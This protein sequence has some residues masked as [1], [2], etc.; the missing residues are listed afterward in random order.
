[1]VTKGETWV[2]GK[3]AA[4]DEYT[5]ITIC[6]IDNN[7]DLLYSTENSPQYSVITYHGK[8]S[9]KVCTDTH[10]HTHIH[11]AELAVHWKPTQ[12][13]KSDQTLTILE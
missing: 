1:L 10:T 6:K 12:N 3:S 5:H 2:R 13:C 8:E 7:K 11:I 9:I 4:W